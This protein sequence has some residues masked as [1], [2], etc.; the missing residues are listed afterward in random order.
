MHE[1]I[2]CEELFE[3]ANHNWLD[4]I[5]MCHK[6]RNEHFCKVHTEV[7][8]LNPDPES[9]RIHLSFWSGYKNQK[10]LCIFI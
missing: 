3:F 10:E 8:D 5:V 9:I 7:A 6:L 2:N 1:T 4:Q